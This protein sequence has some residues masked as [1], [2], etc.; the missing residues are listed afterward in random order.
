MISL[1][2]VVLAAVMYTDAPG[3]AARFRVSEDGRTVCVNTARLGGES[4]EA[5]SKRAE[6]YLELAKPV[7]PDDRRCPLM[8]WS[9]YKAF[10]ADISKDRI[11]DQ[12]RIIATNGLKE[13]GYVY[14]N[15]DDGFMEGHDARGA[16]IVDQAKFPGGLRETVDGIHALGLKAGIYSPAGFDEKFLWEGASASVADGLYGHEDSDCRFFF[17]DL[18]FDFL[19]VNG[20]FAARL[21]NAD[22]KAIFMR[23]VEAVRRTGRD[24]RVNLC[25]QAFPGTW[26]DQVAES[27]RIGEDVLPS[28]WSAQKQIAESFYTSA[29]VSPGHYNDMD[30][31][32]IGRIRS[33]NV[34]NNKSGFF[35]E[36]EE[37]TYFGMCCMQSSPLVVGRDLHKLPASTLKLMTNPYLLRMNQNEGV[38]VQGYI[39]RNDGAGAC[40]FVKDADERFGRSRYVAFYNGSEGEHEFRISP[41]ELDLGGKVEMFDL[42]GR[43]DCGLLTEDWSVTV[44]PHG[45]MFYRLDAE[46]RLEQVIYEAEAAFL[47]D[48][49]TIRNGWEAGTAYPV[50]GPYADKASGG[51]VVRYLGRRDTNDLTWKDVM[52][53]KGGRRTLEIRGCSYRPYDIYVQVDD[54][55]RMKLHFKQER[56]HY[57]TVSLEVELTEGLHRIRLFNSYE[58]GP[59]I[60]KMEIR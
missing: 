31:M 42:V 52:I 59:D 3:D 48:Y 60:D 30:V 26:V 17:C 12:A 34:F 10:G 4:K 18:G 39:V 53:R 15:I 33:E 28:W 8:G 40:V 24:V 44:P 57:Q 11:L 16:I 49:Q 58:W 9:S 36:L 47:G 13:A 23:I 21:R 45:A 41:R 25:A 19:K 56:E 14:V 22:H 27:W 38:G 1:A 2:P 6:R 37:Q 29:Y 32:P 43:A 7:R 51:M 50:E 46:E 20:F 55:P 35:S 5:V 54:G